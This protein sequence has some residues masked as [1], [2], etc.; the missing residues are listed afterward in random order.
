[1]IDLKINEII[2]NLIKFLF[3]LSVFS[4]FYERMNYDFNL[5]PDIDNYLSDYRNANWSYEFGYEF[6]GY[7]FRDIVGL[8]FED[9]WSSLIIV[10]IIML[11]ILYLRG[12]EFIYAVPNIFL[13]SEYFYGTTVRYSIGCLLFLLFFR[14]ENWLEKG[15][16]FS[17]L[18]H[19]GLFFAL[20]IDAIKN[21]LG[22]YLVSRNAIRQIIVIAIICLLFVFIK[23]IVIIL[24]P[25]TRF[26]YYASSYYL[27]AKSISSTIYIFIY[28]ILLVLSVR[29]DSQLLQDKI[30][31]L[32][33]SLLTFCATTA[34]IAVLSGRVLLLFFLIE[35]ILINKLLHKKSTSVIGFLMLTLTMS[36]IALFLI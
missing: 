31:L 16:Y 8:K 26:S 13:M 15:K 25:Y 18:L 11:S 30:I 35:P 32:S 7:F 2:Y 6:I 36:K 22:F 3:I 20:A 29:F 10:Q 12:G 5:N 34:G 17:P 23:S 9:Y 14:R 19:Y 4:L 21:K 27:D 33:L 28:L 1:M 24:L